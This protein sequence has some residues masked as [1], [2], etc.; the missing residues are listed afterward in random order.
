MCAISTCCTKVCCFCSASCRCASTA[1]HD[2]R[3]TAT[4]PNSSDLLIHFSNMFVPIYPFA[5]GLEFVYISLQG[6][7][8]NLPVAPLYSD[9]V[10]GKVRTLPAPATIGG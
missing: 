6:I 9:S 4:K 7:L 1:A 2:D 10:A 5:S 3:A 8:S